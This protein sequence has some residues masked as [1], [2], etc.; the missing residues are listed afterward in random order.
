MEGL[1]SLIAGALVT[2]NYETGKAPDA[3]GLKGVNFAA[4][5]TQAR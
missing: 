4:A 1:G 2:V 3:N 5:G